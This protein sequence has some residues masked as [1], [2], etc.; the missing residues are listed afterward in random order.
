[1]LQWCVMNISPTIR[2][3]LIFL[4]FLQ[5][6]FFVAI[7]TTALIVAAPSIATSFSLGEPFLPWILN[8]YFLTMFVALIAFLIFEKQFSRSMSAKRFFLEGMIYFILGSVIA[9][10]ADS[11]Q[12]FFFA[13]IVQGIGAAMVSVGQLWAMTESYR[14]AIEEPLLWADM[15]FVIG[16]AA[17]PFL[18]GIFSGISVDG[19]R[20]IF[21]LNAVFAITGALLFAW[22]YRE[23]RVTQAATVF[24]GDKKS[25][26]ASFFWVMVIELIVSVVVVAQ[27]FV[28]STYLQNVRDFTPLATGSVLFAASVGVIVGGFSVVASKKTDTLAGISSGLQGMVVAIVVFGLA[29]HFDIFVPILFSLFLSGLFFGR[30]GILLFSYISR[31][32]APAALVSGTIIYLIVLQLGNAFGVGMETL[33][34][35]INN[36]FLLFSFLLVGLLQVP[37][38]CVPQLRAVGR[39]EMNTN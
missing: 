32:L 33:W 15:G 1:M 28:V 17:G 29:F 8:A 39:G 10:V 13:R 20:G 3:Y 21:L 30:L 12:L 23:K 4:T 26:P 36:D 11:A 27:E 35:A 24:P 37:L 19:W 31:L 34:A 38:F 2:K 6:D 14:D 18:G 5:V 25:F 22:L 7:E 9:G 16:I